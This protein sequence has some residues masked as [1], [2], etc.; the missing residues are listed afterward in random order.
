MEYKV[1]VIIPVYKVEKFIERCTRS[2]MEQT[3]LEVE[4][5]FVDDASPDASISV[6]HQVLAEYP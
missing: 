4:Y 2:L 5:I 1:S 6:L 3:M